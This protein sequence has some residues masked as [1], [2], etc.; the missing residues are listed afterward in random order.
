MHPQMDT[1]CLFQIRMDQDIYN[2]TMTSPPS[3]HTLAW[4]VEILEMNNC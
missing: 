4:Q 2:D 3:T 1:K